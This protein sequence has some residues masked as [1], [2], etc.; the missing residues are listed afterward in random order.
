METNKVRSK[1]H[2]SIGR[3]NLKRGAREHEAPLRRYSEKIVVAL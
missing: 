1:I 2:V 3:T